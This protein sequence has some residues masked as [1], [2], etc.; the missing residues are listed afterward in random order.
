[1]LTRTNDLNVTKV[2]YLTCRLS[3]SFVQLASLILKQYV[4]AHWNKESEKFNPPVTTDEVIIDTYVM[5]LMSYIFSFFFFTSL[6][7]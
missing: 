4:E 2:L 1:M 6:I 7:F 5:T 3:C